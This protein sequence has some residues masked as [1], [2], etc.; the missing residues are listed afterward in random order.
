MADKGYR[1]ASFETEL[2]TRGVTL[3]RPTFGKDTRPTRP[4]IPAAIPPDHRVDQPDPQSPTRPRTPRRPQTRRRLRPRP[5]T[6]PRPHRRHLAQRNHQPT[7]PRPITPRLRPLT[8]LG[9]N[10]LAAT[11]AVPCR[12]QSC[13]A[14]HQLE[15]LLAQWTG[16][17]GDVTRRSGRRP[18]MSAACSRACRWRRARPWRSRTRASAP[19]RR[20]GV[21]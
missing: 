5:P 16:I 14:P 1:S 9:T 12:Q 8:P 13:A 20:R 17:P 21:A 11:P 15:A 6:T 18:R 2:N 10:H 7:R 3:I 4:T 19:C